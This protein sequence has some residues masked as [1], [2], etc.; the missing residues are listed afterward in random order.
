MERMDHTKYSGMQFA[1]HGGT[2]AGN[3]IALAAGLATID[4]LEHKPVYEHVNRL[5][6]K[7][8]DMLNRIFDENAFSAQATG[9]GSLLSIHTTAKKPVRDARS[10]SES[11][12]EKSRELFE[13]LLQL[14]ILMIVPEMLHGSISYAHTEADIDHL[15]STVERFVK[16]NSLTGSAG[17]ARMSST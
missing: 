15:T 2:F 13:Y 17:R 3:A 6:E 5:G 9:I 11:D 7:A 4:V 14:G 12:H 10:Y 8:R 16:Q 1:Y